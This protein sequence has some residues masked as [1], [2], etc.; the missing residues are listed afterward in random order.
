[1]RPVSADRERSVMPGTK[2]L[3]DAAGS[4]PHPC[5]HS[6]SQSVSAAAAAAT[7]RQSAWN[8]DTPCC[9]HSRVIPEHLLTLQLGEK[10][11]THWRKLVTQWLRFL[12]H[13][14]TSFPSVQRSVI[15]KQQ[16]EI[17]HCHSLISILSCEKLVL[18]RLVNCL[19]TAK[20]LFNQSCLHN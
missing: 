1:M 20:K 11:V 17:C 10:N 18:M 14:V 12:D 3:L 19:L 9:S 16:T 13:W 15:N 7:T 2:L 8:H 6:V 5:S 4:S